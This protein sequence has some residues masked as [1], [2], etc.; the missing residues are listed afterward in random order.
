MKQKITFPNWTAPAYMMIS[1]GGEDGKRPVWSGY[2]RDP[3]DL[4]SLR[5]TVEIAGGSCLFERFESKE[6]AEAARI[7]SDRRAAWRN[8]LAFAEQLW[9]AAP[10]RE[11]VVHFR[12]ENP[13]VGR[14]AVCVYQRL[15]PMAENGAEVVTA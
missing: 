3:D 5:V 11:Y 13:N 14:E 12:P 1:S 2:T 8:A 10:N 15:K 6:A 7:E 4:L 9:R